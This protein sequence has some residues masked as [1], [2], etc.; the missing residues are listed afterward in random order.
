MWPAL[1][2]GCRAKCGK[3]ELKAGACCK[4]CPANRVFR[5]MTLVSENLVLSGQ[6]EYLV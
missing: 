3:E 5:K 4:N 1:L 6:R 2:A